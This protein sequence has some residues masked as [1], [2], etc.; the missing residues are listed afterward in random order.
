MRRVCNAHVAPTSTGPCSGYEDG[1][2]LA[3]VG[4]S[5]ES[6]EAP[7]TDFGEGLRIRELEQTLQI[8][9]VGEV[10][11]AGDAPH[12]AL[13][14]PCHELAGPGDAKGVQGGSL[15]FR[16]IAVDLGLA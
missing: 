3:R 7:D 8:G 16:G 1:E 12:G 14:D 13:L 10:R 15:V 2:A 11:G 6:V 4:V 5:R 9:A